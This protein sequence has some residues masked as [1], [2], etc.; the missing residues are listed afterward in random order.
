ME[1]IIDGVKYIPA[2]EAIANRDA[3][4]RGLMEQFWGNLGETY[5]E[6]DKCNGVYCIVTDDPSRYNNP[7]TVQQVADSIAEFAK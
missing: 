5:D 2:K 4:I 1:V 3:V 7:R 6:N